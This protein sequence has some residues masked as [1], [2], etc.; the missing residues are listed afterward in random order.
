MQFLESSNSTEKMVGVV[1]L[2]MVV[3]IMEL[4]TVGGCKIY[5]AVTKFSL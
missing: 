2:K 4:L 1:R 3:M 5:E